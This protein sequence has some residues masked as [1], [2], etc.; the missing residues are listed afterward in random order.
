MNPKTI[1]KTIIVSYSYTGN[2][3]LLAQ[4]LHAKLN[5]DIEKIVEVRER[6]VMTTLLDILLRSE[7]KVEVSKAFLDTYDFVILVA[8]VWNGRIASPLASF[9]ARE[10]HNIRNYAFITICGGQAGQ[11]EKLKDQLTGIMQQNPIALC[12]LEVNSLLPP[13]ERGNVRY[14]TPYRLK[15]S[16]FRVLDGPIQQFL[17]DVIDFEDTHSVSAMRRQ[18]N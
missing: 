18:L 8:P 11:F 6:T 13:N 2:N 7:P 15:Q 17:D 3:D 5:C 10:K 14:T 12:E 9:L 4:R 1:M 16:D